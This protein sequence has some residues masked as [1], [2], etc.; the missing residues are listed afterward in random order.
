MRKPLALVAAA[1]A[2]AGAVTLPSVAQAAVPASLAG[3]VS[4][5]DCS[6]SLVKLSSS[7]PT[8]KALIFTN[9][10]CLK[11]MG[12]DEVIVNRAYTETKNPQVLDANGNAVAAVRRTRILYAT[13]SGTDVTIYQTAETY[14]DL[15]AK[16][17]PMLELSS[18]HPTAGTQVFVPSSYWRKSY[19]CAVDGFV[20][21]LKEGVHTWN[22]SI[23]YTTACKVE[24]GSSGSPIVYKAS[25]KIIGINNTVNESGERC[26]GNNPCEVDANGAVKVDRGRGYGQQTYLV[27]GCLGANSTIDLTKSGCALAKPKA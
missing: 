23:R 16:G 14:G 9:G 19:Q 15:S 22:D 18:A 2:V 10:H 27:Y 26:T 11:I 17:A 5:G 21:Q 13:M 25:G 8:D 12:A 24:P 3:T 1:L 6:Y 7:K 20:H 4:V